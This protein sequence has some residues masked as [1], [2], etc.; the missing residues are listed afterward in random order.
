MRRGLSTIFFNQPIK[1]RRSD[2]NATSL[3]GVDELA[4]RVDT[5]GLR[6]EGNLSHYR[7]LTNEMAEITDMNL[8]KLITKQGAQH[9]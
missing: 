4:L 7:S 5:E 2:G 6:N 9:D 1:A 3:E 8:E